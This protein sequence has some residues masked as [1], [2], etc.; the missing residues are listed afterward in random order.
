MKMLESVILAQATAAQDYADLSKLSSDK[1]ASEPVSARTRLKADSTGR[2][3]FAGTDA[4]RFIGTRC[5]RRD[6]RFGS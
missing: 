3:Q 4:G 5:A 2:V 1:V 6:P